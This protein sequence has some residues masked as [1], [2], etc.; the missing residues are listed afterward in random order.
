MNVV[1]K[2]SQAKT[3]IHIYILS[4]CI[5]DLTCFF[6]NFE[7]IFIGQNF[8]QNCISICTYVVVVYLFNFCL[9][10][11]LYLSLFKVIFICSSEYFQRNKWN[12]N[13]MHS[14]Y[15]NFSVDA[16]NDEIVQSLL[17]G[18][19]PDSGTSFAGTGLRLYTE[20]PGSEY[21]WGHPGQ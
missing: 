2:I 12:Q 16:R 10:F 14:F 7:I 5:V 11:T 17:G 20:D 21:Q 3:R 9:L 4:K 19:G 18:E 15:L 1:N 8:Y 6:L 13:C